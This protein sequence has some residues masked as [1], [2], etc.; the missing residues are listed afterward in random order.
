[1]ISL[2]EGGFGYLPE[3]WVFRSHSLEV[4]T[5]RIA[6]ILGPNGRGKTTLL[7]CLLG[8]LRLREGKV[9][10]D[11]HAGYVPQSTG[12]AFPYSVR[13]MVMMGRARQIGLF[14]SPKADDQDACQR[15]LAT[16]DLEN[17]ADRSFDGLSGG[18]RQLVLVA[19]ALASECR[20]LVLDEPAAALDYNNQ[21]VV[22][23]TLRRLARDQG[24]A[25]VF[26]THSPQHALH[27]ADQVFLMYGP[28]DYICGP[29]PEVMTEDNLSRL[30]GLPIRAAVVSEDGRDARTMV[31]VFG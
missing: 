15:A 19:R 26:T 18:E 5:G 20:T 7:K 28:E 4:T 30:Y 2:A 14:E 11:G 6:A 29:T 9:Q 12:A 10:I 8:L 13:D 31:P 16:L 23:K 21:E 22:L 24:L 17:F 25:V 3:S 27:V 1:M